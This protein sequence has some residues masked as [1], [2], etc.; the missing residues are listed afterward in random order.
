MSLSKDFFNT[1][2]KDVAVSAAAFNIY[3]IEAFISEYI[4]ELIEIGDLP[5][6]QLCENT[7]HVG[8]K[9]AYIHGFNI[10]TNDNTEAVTL[11]LIVTRS[12]EHTSEL[13][14]REN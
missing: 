4:H 8:S 9:G 11:N 1:L 10:D 2:K 5:D 6:F 13:Q 3:S 7:N 12:E 14:S